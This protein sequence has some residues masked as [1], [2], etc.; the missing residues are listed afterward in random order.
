MHETLKVDGEIDMD[1]H[2][3]VNIRYNNNKEEGGITGPGTYVLRDGK[4]VPGTGEIR[5]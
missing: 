3:N 1:M 4:L 2:G 5:E